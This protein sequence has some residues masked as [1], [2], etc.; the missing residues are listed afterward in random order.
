M[1]ANPSKLFVGSFD[2]QGAFRKEYLHN[3]MLIRLFQI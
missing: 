3:S 1:E 2:L